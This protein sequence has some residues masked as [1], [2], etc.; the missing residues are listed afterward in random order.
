M[1]LRYDIDVQERQHT[2]EHIDD[3]IELCMN[4]ICDTF[5]SVQGKVIEFYVFEK[6]N[7]NECFDKN[8]TKDGIHI[9]INIECDFATKMIFRDYIIKNIDDIWSDLGNTNDWNSVVDEGVMKG[10]VNW[11]LYGSRK[12]GHESYQLKYIQQCE[13]QEDEGM[14]ISEVDVRY[15]NFDEYFP[16]F[17]ARNKY[18][19]HNF[20]LNETCLDIYEK[21]K[22]EFMFKKNRGSKNAQ[23]TRKRNRVGMSSSIDNIQNIEDLDGMIEEWFLDP[24]TEYK[25]KEIHNYVMILQKNF[26]TWVI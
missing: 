2:K 24:D 11:Q 15:I 5:Q 14:E 13:I 25:Y 3:F 6:E 20:R 22:R 1:D 18:N 16:R 12:P 23:K 9:I 4:G 8:I 17:C 10:H 26:R 7:V 21:Y 19:L